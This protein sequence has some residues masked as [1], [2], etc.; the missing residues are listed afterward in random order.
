MNDE[1]TLVRIEMLYIKNA[2]WATRVISFCCENVEFQKYLKIAPLTEKY[3]K[4]SWH[5]NNVFERILYCMSSSGVRADYGRDLFLK[6]KNHFDTKYPSLDFDF[7]VTERKIKCFKSL[8]DK[9]LFHNMTPDTLTYQKFHEFEFQNVHGIGETTVSH[10]NMIH[11][12]DFSVLP[13]TDMYF[14]RGLERMFGKQ[15]NKKIREILSKYVDRGV[16]CAMISNIGVYGDL[17]L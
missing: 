12:N 16:L 13:M 5:P 8:I 1:Q 3:I 4:E 2:D 15:T 17:V 11:G 6:V 10:V 7:K 14:K 9:M